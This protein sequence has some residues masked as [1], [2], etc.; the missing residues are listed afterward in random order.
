[1]NFSGLRKGSL[2]FRCGLAT[3]TVAAVFCVI[4]IATRPAQAQT[5]TTLYDF[6][7]VAG[8]LDGSGANGTLISD[9]SGNLYGTTQYGGTNAAGT[10]YVLSPEG[11]QTVLHDFF[12]FTG[13][14]TYPE[15][16]LIMDSQGNLFGVTEA[17][18]AYGDGG[19]GTV[20]RLSP[21][22]SET[23]LHSFGKNPNDGMAPSGFLAIDKQGNIYG[24]TNGGGKYGY[25]TAFRISPDGAETIIHTFNN[26]SGDGYYPGGLAIDRLG[27]LYGTCSAG[28]SAGNG[29]VFEINN[30]G[31]YTTLYNFGTNSADGT[32]PI[33][34]VILNSRGDLFGVTFLGG[35]YNSGVLYALKPGSPWTERIIYT[36]GASSTDAALPWGPL[37]VDAQGNFYSES[38][39]GGAYTFGTVFKITP[40]GTETILYNFTNGSDG[41]FPN[42]GLLRD[43]S[44]N[45]YG[46][47]ISGGSHNNG[48]IYKITP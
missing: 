41:G 20:F 48:A 39:E 12:A 28:G 9:S 36:F 31:G 47:D 35:L 22:G 24:T 33:G 5:E 44:G 25:G 19:Y 46:T 14:G 45:F 23:I 17:G 8:C 16:G 15:E 2:E 38:E 42:S 29:T 18:G 32:S 11:E 34:P 6:C 21:G 3:T 1:V 10:A 26:K 43:S 40:A 7:S 27:N 13:D 30:K 37:I 4:L